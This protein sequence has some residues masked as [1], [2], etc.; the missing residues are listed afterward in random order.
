MWFP[1]TILRHATAQLCE[2]LSVNRDATSGILLSVTRP[3][4]QEIPFPE[5]PTL[6]RFLTTSHL[7]FTQLGLTTMSAAP[8]LSPT[9]RSYPLSLRR[10]RM[11][12]LCYYLA[13][14][15]CQNHL[16][17]SVRG[18][19]WPSW[20]GPKGDGTTTE[21]HIP[22]QW[23][24]QKNVAWKIPLP[25]PG[26]SSPVVFGDSIFLTQ[27]ENEGKLRS[28]L[29]F[30]VEN[31]E[32][33]WRLTLEVNEPEPTHPTNPH[34]AGSPVTDGQHVIAMLGAAGVVCCD[35]NG[36]LLWKKELGSPQHLFGQGPSPIIWEDVCILNYGPGQQQFFIGLKLVD[37][38]ELWRIDI[39]Q[40]TAP[41]P[42]DQPDGPKLPE[43][44]T[45]RDPFGTWA[46]PVIRNS[47]N[48]TAEVLL[49]LPEKLLAV[50]PREGKVLWECEGNGAQ[51]LSTPIHNG[52]HIACLGGSAFVVEPE[53]E[54]DQL[55]KRLWYNDVDRQRI[56]S[57]I[58]HEGQIY[59]ATV[60]GILESIDLE[61]GKRLWHRRLSSNTGGGA[62][63]SSLIKADSKIYAID[64]AG[65]THVYLLEPEFLEVASN[66]LGESTNSTPAIADGKIFI[67]TE[68]HLWCIAEPKP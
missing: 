53:G 63:W 12:P 37:G 39:P 48:Q 45:L 25:G 26:N 3:Q 36:Q 29:C 5:S 10:L 52:S 1:W 35:M 28:L 67:R 30:A 44:A 60:Q 8:F 56:G 50:T 38:N 34:C 18:D 6:T 23:D 17:D 49:S 7:L 20:R 16:V 27:A 40:S 58:I 15:C 9:N 19:N 51:V 66:P 68:K 41:N 14:L 31:G 42:F 32:E 64:Q 61:N 2:I 57:G 21:T 46:T 55:S 43:G 22:V 33:K 4:R 11:V 47:V 13:L 24:S 54:G 62:I 59:V 65:T